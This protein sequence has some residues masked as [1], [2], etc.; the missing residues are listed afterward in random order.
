[1]LFFKYIRTILQ[2]HLNF[3]PDIFWLSH[4]LMDGFQKYF[5]LI[6]ARSFKKKKYPT[7]LNKVIIRVEIKD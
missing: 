7:H 4:K 3:R 5:L 2:E 6:I 1:M